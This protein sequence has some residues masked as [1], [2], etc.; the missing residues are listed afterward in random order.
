MTVL[1]VFV[2][3]FALL[4]LVGRLNWQPVPPTLDEAAVRASG[5]PLSHAVE[6]TDR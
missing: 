2:L 3:F 5:W 6:V 1:L 4:I